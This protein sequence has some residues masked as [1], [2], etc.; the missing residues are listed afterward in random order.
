MESYELGQ[1]ELCIPEDMANLQLPDPE[2]LNYYHLA[3]DRIFYLDYD[4]GDA[5]LAL[6]RT[7]QVLNLKDRVLPAEQR[8]PIKIFIF[9]EGGS[10]YH[11]YSLIAAIEQS[12][13][14]VWT[15]NAGVAYSAGLLIFLAG[16][17]RLCYRRSEALIHNG[18]GQIS[19][20]Y[21]QAAEGME[22]YKKMVAAM[23]DYI[24]EKTKIDPKLFKKN[25]AKDWFIT[26]QE[27][28]ELG[29]AEKIIE[30]MDEVL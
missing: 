20:T 23:H 6:A 22:S 9:S 7:I 2:L 21:D 24:L 25:K 29:I 30:S 11:C 17:R 18:S 27:Q 5:C 14:P 8:T 10:M 16:Q 3:N 12:V 19:G 15:I 4:V 1:V 26:D 13:T 28:I